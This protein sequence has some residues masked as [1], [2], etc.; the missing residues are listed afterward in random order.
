MGLKD[1]AV[2][3]DSDAKADRATAYALSLAR[4]FDAH[5]TGIATAID[6]LIPAPMMGEIP[7]DV[8]V[9]AF[10]KAQDVAKQACA[11]FA[12]AAKRQHL[13]YDTHLIAG[14]PGA[15]YER[16]ARFIRHFDLTVIQQ[17]TPETLG[18]EA[19][20][21]ETALFRSG[22]PALVVPHNWDKPFKCERIIVAWNQSPPAARAISDAL[23]LLKL[24]KSVEVVT[25][26][27]SAETDID[28]PGFNITRHLARYNVNAKLNKLSGKTDVATQ[29]LSRLHE[30]ES[31]LLVMGGY[32][33]SRI[34]EFIW[35]GATRGIL[36]AMTAPVFIAH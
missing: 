2:F 15:V 9:A 6:M 21:I 13:L 29:V 32:G 22:R 27:N 34:S 24:A 16:F 10:E 30:L 35:G 36:K 7:S 1:I 8:F 4:S 14:L 33:H 19:A 31:D 26:E 18:D 11:N 3:I 23:P 17:P 12:A 28:L 25:V 5:V 20:F